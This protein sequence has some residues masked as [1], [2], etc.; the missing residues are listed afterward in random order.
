ML[1][2]ITSLKHPRNCHSYERVC[3]LLDRT[4]DSVCAQ[5]NPDFSVIVVCNQVPQI[6]LRPNVHYVPV[7][8]PAPSEKRSPTTGM[9]AIWTDR[10]SKY[11]IGLIYARKFAPNHIMFFDADDYVSRNLA[12]YVSRTPGADGWYFDRGYVYKAGACTISLMRW[13]FYARCG[14]S[15]IVNYRNF[16]VPPDLGLDSGLDD[17][18]SKTDE[19]YLKYVL[20]GH[21]KIKSYLQERGA[22]L[23]ELPAIGAVWVQGNG[24]NHSGNPGMTGNMALTDEI[25]REFTI[26][27][28]EGWRWLR[29]RK[30]LALHRIH[31]WF[32]G[33][34]QMPGVD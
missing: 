30:E 1:T 15:G 9:G 5:S 23:K 8:F 6:P 4:L 21:K 34:P 28:P 18:F 25:C 2:F 31:S 10:G 19:T 33:Q 7:D 17:I 16:N 27:V 13:G 26:P 14:T 29:T 32:P 22:S 3:Q 20:G 24:E 11:L 12:E